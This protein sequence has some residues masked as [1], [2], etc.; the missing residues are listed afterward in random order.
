MAAELDNSS[1][2]L[3]QFAGATMRSKIDV[4]RNANLVRLCKYNLMQSGYT[5]FLYS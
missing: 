4:V 1:A 2:I 3:K 5:A